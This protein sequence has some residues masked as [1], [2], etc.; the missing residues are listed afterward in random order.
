MVGWFGVREDADKTQPS[1]KTKCQSFVH[2]MIWSG[3]SLIMVWMI[4]YR[5]LCMLREGEG[6]KKGVR[7]FCSTE[8]VWDLRRGLVP[9]VFGLTAH[10][11]D[12]LCCIAFFLCCIAAC[13]CC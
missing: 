9:F 2:D 7:A 1:P 3:I 13:W 4:V 8:S 5:F 10:L 6:K 12:A 11:I